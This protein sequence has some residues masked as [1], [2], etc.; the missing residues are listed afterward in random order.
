MI[1]G[2]WSHMIICH[3]LPYMVAFVS[4]AYLSSAICMGQ[5]Y[6]EESTSLGIEHLHIGPMLMGGGAAFLDF[7]AD[8]YEDLYLT[9]GT[10]ADKL[11]RNNGNSTFTDVTLSAGIIGTDSINTMGV[12]AGDLDNDGFKEIFVT[13]WDGYANILFQNN[14]DGT[15]QDVSFSAGIIDSALSVSATLGDVN[16]DGFLDIYV[17]NYIDL[18][19]VAPNGFDYTCYANYLYI[20]NGNNTFTESGLAYGV[21]DTG[22][23]LAVAFTDFDDSGDMDVY[24]ANDFGKWVLPNALYENNYPTPNHSNITISAGVNDSIFGMGIAI[25]DYDEDGDFDY[26]ITNLGRNVLRQNQGNGTLD[27][28]TDTAGVTN[29]YTDSTFM[30]V[31]W[32]TAFFDYDNDTYLDLIVSNGYIPA[33]SFIYNT[34]S[35]PNKLYRN[36]GGVAFQDVSDGTGFN[37]TTIGRGLAIGDYNYDGAID[38]VVGVVYIDTT[39][40]NRTLVYNN[41]E[42][43][44]NWLKISLQ[45][46]ITNRDAFGSHVIVYAAGRQFIREVDGG[47]SHLSHSSSTLHFGLGSIP[48]VD[49]IVVSWLNGGKDTLLNVAVNQQVHLVEDSLF[50]TLHYQKVQICSGDSAFL[51]GAYQFNQGTYHDTLSSV[52]GHDSIVHSSLAFSALVTDTVQIAICDGDSVL[53]GGAFQVSSGIY[54]D[55]LTGVTC[56]SAIIT[57]LTVLNAVL[58]IISDT[59]CAGELF[60]GEPYTNDTI[61]TN[62]LTASSGCDSVLT[63][64]LSVWPVSDVVVDTTICKGELYFGTLY[65]SATTI[66]DSLSTAMGCDS[67]VTTNLQVLNPD[68]SSSSFSICEGDLV[69]G[70]PVS[71]DTSIVAVYNGVNGCDSV[72]ITTVTVF[73]PAAS[74]SNLTVDWG[75]TIIGIVVFEDTILFDTLISSNGCDSVSQLTVTVLLPDNIA[76]MSSQISNPINCYPNPF[77]SELNIDLF[78]PLNDDVQ[79]TIHDLTGTKVAVVYAGRL[80]SGKHALKWSGT[81]ESGCAV[82]QGLYICRLLSSGAFSLHQ[83][84]LMK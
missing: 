20:N 4:G 69:G 41:G 39:N 12:V 15:F 83:I 11:Y 31:G 17:G 64:N 16:K 52:Y 72:T 61:L 65:S 57:E 30:A 26:Y 23:A 74:T 38:V 27:D 48:M 78:M 19:V 70:Q 53:A 14:G 28:Y 22:C 81:T 73:P 40:G 55:T 71:S 21:A 37:D 46:V 50:F 6:V 10:A 42:Q 77:T 2:H 67:I 25:G 76:D 75:D 54:T 8:G 84:I 13:T 43:G 51:G 63:I 7:D 66:V 68:S 29:T 24:L 35:N 34:P 44:N 32:G 56:D 80:G 59:I 62:V 45:G 47:S 58:N 82:S 33:D 79:V 18:S 36:T 60:E 3:K 1:T 9:G 49:S 5:G